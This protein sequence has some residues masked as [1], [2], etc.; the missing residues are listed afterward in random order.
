[1]KRFIVAPQAESDLD[2]IL[3]YLA[4]ENEQAATKLLARIYAAI[5][6]L[7]EFP[8]SG[9]RRPDLAGTRSLLFWPVDRYLILYRPLGNLIE[10]A[11]VLHGSRDIPEIL[12]DRDPAE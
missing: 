7:S 4:E 12:R 1:M 2:G 10:I 6:M 8:V 9:H 11:A 3:D 5:E